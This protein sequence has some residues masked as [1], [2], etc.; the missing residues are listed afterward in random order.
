MP[1]FRN[2]SVEI[3]Y[4]DEGRGEP[5]VLVHRV[6]ANKEDWISSG[7][8]SALTEAGRRVIALDN[9][10][11]GASSRPSYSGAYD[12]APMARDVLALMD[13]L[14]IERADIMGYSMGA[15]IA[16]HALLAAP[17][18]F[19]A[20]IIAGM[21]FNLLEGL[22]GRNAIADVLEAADA[23]TDG[24]SMAHEFR[25][26]ARQN[27]NDLKAI[28]ACFRGS[29]TLSREQLGT[30]SVPVLVA[31]G[32]EDDIARPAPEGGSTADAL[33]RLIPG[34]KA[35]DIPDQNHMHALGDP[36]FKKAVF[37]F[38]KRTRTPRQ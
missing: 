11:H 36:A 26:F 19:H 30:I 5:I 33:A 3:S 2:E 20:G 16:M 12:G 1:R 27:G 24:N 32:T 23:P 38:L 10:G 29:R 18:R 37:A 17:K 6:A 7:W 28:A 34:A 4:L 9:R 35:F 14:S 22:G 21:G 15:G 31:V 25:E 8:V 13:H